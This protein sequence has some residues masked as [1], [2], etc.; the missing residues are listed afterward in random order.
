MLVLHRL[1]YLQYAVT[2]RQF[3][4]SY[5]RHVSQ[6]R[7]LWIRKAMNRDGLCAHFTLDE[8][9]LGNEDDDDDDNELRQL[10]IN[11]AWYIQ[12]NCL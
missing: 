4:S 5:F 6:L 9:C 1:D 3:I 12:S 8:H 11:V 10:Y 7:T 2:Y